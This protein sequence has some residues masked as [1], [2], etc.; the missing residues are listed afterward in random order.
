MSDRGTIWLTI[1]IVAVICIGLRAAGPMLLRDRE[2]PG[3]AT[4]VIDMMAPA[5]LAGLIVVELLGAHWEHL[6]WT[7][8]PALPIAAALRWWKVPELACIAVAI[9]VTVL[10]RAVF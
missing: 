8:L 1:G 3:P 5:L 9:A 6:D 7:M 4:A 2:L 10:L